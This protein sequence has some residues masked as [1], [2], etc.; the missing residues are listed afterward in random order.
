MTAAHAA[1]L[2]LLRAWDQTQVIRFVGKCS[3]L[4]LGHLPRP[5]PAFEAQK[6]FHFDEL[7]LDYFSYV[8][9][10]V[11]GYIQ[12]ITAKTNIMKFSPCFLLTVLEFLA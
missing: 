6:T 8:A 5:A 11:L 10:A 4:L 7:Q 3:D 2:L 12:E 9:C 1:A